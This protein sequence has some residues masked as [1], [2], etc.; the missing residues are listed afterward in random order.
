MR[1]EEGVMR[2]LAREWSIPHRLT[3]AILLAASAGARATTLH[4]PSVYATINAALDTAV[5]GDTV[6]VAPGT[7]TTAE[8]RT[9]DLGGGIPTPTV[10]LAFL[11]DGVVV[12]SEAGPQTTVLDLQGQTACWAAVVVATFLQSQQT[13]LDGFTVTGSPL[14]WNGMLVSECGKVTVR[15]CVFQDLD[16]TALAGYGGGWSVVLRVSRSRERSFGTA[17]RRLEAA[18]G[19]T[20]EIRSSK[21]MSASMAASS[22]TA[23]RGLWTS[24]G[25]TC[26]PRDP[27]Q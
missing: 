25:T 3:L 9:V 11:K 14:G 17:T 21:G 1:V 10:S 20:R 5:M 22:R 13:V 16:A 12:K 2:Y 4:V 6:L 7:Y 26:S 24:R 18:S 23:P 19:S 8:V 15:N 27:R